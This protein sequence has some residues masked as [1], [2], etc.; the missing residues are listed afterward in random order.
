M[1]SRSSRVGFGSRPAPVARFL[2]LAAL[3]WRRPSSAAHAAVKAPYGSA[4]KTF[5]GPFDSSDPRVDVFYPTGTPAG[6]RFTLVAWA[7]GLWGGGD[8]DWVAYTP[9]LKQWAAH[10]FVIVAPRA[11]NNGCHDSCVSIPGGPECFG[12]YYLQ[13]IEALKWVN[14][15]NLTEDAAALLNPLVNHTHGYGIGG[16]SMGGQATLFSGSYANATENKIRAAIMMHPYTHEFPSLMVPF[17]VMTG[18]ADGTALPSVSRKIFE[19]RAGNGA[20]RDRGFVNKKGASH[21][22]PL[23]WLNDEA[24]ATFSAAFMKIHV[25]QVTHDEHANYTALIYGNGSGSLCGGGDGEMVEC[26]VKSAR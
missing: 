5:S 19:T 6:R 9:M 12:T 10:G 11:C 22:E 7:H 15:K 24:L 23:F 20:S 1:R 16:H 8:I 14:G 18:D 25:E 13:Q 26:D 21:L 17:L 3:C 2:L 4:H